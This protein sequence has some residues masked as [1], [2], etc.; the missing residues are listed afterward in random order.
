MSGRE[1]VNIPTNVISNWRKSSRENLSWI[2]WSVWYTQP[3]LE[4]QQ[5]QEQKGR[6]FNQIKLE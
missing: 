5:F 4:D 3:E 6:I 2:T 1:Y